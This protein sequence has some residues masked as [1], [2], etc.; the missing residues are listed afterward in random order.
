MTSPAN[1]I[2]TGKSME[3][4][5]AGILARLRAETRAEHD[6]I[7]AALDLIGPGLTLA[8]Y[9]LRLEQFHGFYR[10]V[11]E[12]LLAA[13]GWAGRGLDL[14][15][16][17]KTPL[18]VADLAALGVDALELPVCRDLPPLSDPAACFGCLYVLEG[19]S[20]GGQVITRHVRSA[21]GI[22]PGAGGLFF[23]GYGE[24]TGE[25]WRSFRG[26]LA[27]FAG[28]SGADDRIVASAIAT[29]RKLRLWCEGAPAP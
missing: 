10:P 6:A 29:F 7:E 18:L 24:R 16:R 17:Q 2:I 4:S 1:E 25:M 9:C 26:A 12:R 20:L 5:G 23:H 19:A 28:S 21:L 3:A 22:T 8:A 27:A 13:G 11:E 14:E 15:A